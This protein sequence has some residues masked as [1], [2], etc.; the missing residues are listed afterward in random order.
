MA[1][2]YA[3]LAIRSCDPVYFLFFTTG[4]V[5][6]DAWRLTRNTGIVTLDGEM[7][8]AYLSARNVGVVDS[9]Y[10]REAFS[11]WLAKGV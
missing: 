11:C 3:D 10:E 1:V 7:I 2:K 5:S 8:A 4:A 6:T 9:D